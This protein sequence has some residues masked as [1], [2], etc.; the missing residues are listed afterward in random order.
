MK[1]YK[2]KALFEFDDVEEGTRRFNETKEHQASIWNCTKERYEFLKDHNAVELIE[3]IN[4]E[5]A[6]KEKEQEEK[7]EIEEEI[8]KIVKSRK[9][10]TK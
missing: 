9:R 6:K 3:V 4:E 8:K 7:K 1:I 10:R 5:E 2:V